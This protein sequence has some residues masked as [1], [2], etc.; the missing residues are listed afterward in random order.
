M[1][2]LPVREVAPAHKF[3]E[4]RLGSFL[5]DRIEPFDRLRVQQF[6]GGAS[7][8]TFLLTAEG[9]GAGR[10]YV[11][12]KKP[13]GQLLASAHQVDREYRVM[14][15]LEGSG[16]PVPHMRALCEDAEVIGTAF[17]VM[18]F[19]PGRIFRDAKLPSVAPADRAA[20]YDQLNLTLAKLH[21]VDFEA[22]GLGDFG[23][24]GN[25]FERQIA[26]WIKQYRG[27]ESEHIAEMEELIATL[28][29]L[30]PNDQSV[31][32]AHGDYRLEN[33]MFHPEKPELIAVLDWELCTIGHPIADIAYNSF[34]WHSDGEGWGTLLGV[35]FKKSGIPSE[36]DYVRKYCVRVGRS[37]PIEG[38]NFYQAF[39]VFRLASI[40]Q[41]VYARV[42]A[43]NAST[44]RPAVNG[45]KHLAEQALALLRR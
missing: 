28:P 29:A 21:K 5:K 25:Y 36:E 32:I 10:R 16:V 12:R 40:S 3:D 7:N 37:F 11:L 17:Y 26:R 30:V 15:A 22:R 35:D 44:D 18:D 23:R 31:T 13:P 20:I 8:P 27:A 9:A 33:V 6:Q 39:S 4:K 14:K 1:S 19:L 42:L 43:G 34:L 24:P 45:T 41:G 38:W 2:E